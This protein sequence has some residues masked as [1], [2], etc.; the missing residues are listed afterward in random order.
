M[1]PIAQYIE[2]AIQSGRA[3]N[4]A[5]IARQCG[6]SRPTVSRWRSGER[7][8]DDDEAVM[9]ALLLGRDPGELLAECGAAR[10]RTPETRR[11]WERIAARMAGAAAM[12]IVGT[13]GLA[14]DAQAQGYDNQRVTVF[15]TRLLRLAALIF[16]S[17][18]AYKF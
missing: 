1:K 6:V 3:K 15:R 18:P 9:L 14:P 16:S 7:T 13:T 12:V 11:A 2:E 10:A 5:D 8:P 17:R 4:D